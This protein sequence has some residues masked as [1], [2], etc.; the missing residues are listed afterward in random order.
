MLPE[1]HSL[2]TS[3]SSS[4]VSW[5]SLK[6]PRLSGSPSSIILAHCALVVHAIQHCRDLILY[7]LILAYFM[8]HDNWASQHNIT[9]MFRMIS[10]IMCSFPAIMHQ[11][12]NTFLHLCDAFLHSR[13]ACILTHLCISSRIFILHHIILHFLCI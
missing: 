5:Y 1:F 3:L 10:H 8:A 11:T 9:I 7:R 4:A 6:G 2:T 12:H 13:L